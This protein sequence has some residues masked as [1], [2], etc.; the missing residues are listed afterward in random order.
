MRGRREIRVLE[1]EVMGWPHWVAGS[2]GR[3]NGLGEFICRRLKSQ[4]F[5]RA[6]VQPQSDAVEGRL[7]MQG[8]VG[9]LGEILM[10]QTVGIFIRSA[11][12]GALRVTEVDLHIGGDCEALVIDH[13]FPAIPAQ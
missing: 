1:L 9:S 2:T 5:P 7:W 12:R 8:K 3:R 4:R 11:L 13:F 6:L 10:Q